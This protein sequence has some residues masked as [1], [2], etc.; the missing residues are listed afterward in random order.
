MP[1]TDKRTLKNK[2]LNLIL[3]GIDDKKGN[4][5]TVINLKKFDNT[6]ADYFVITDATTNVQVKAI[7]DNVRK[8]LS[9]DLKAKPLGVEGESL[10]EWILLDYGD[11]IVHVFQRPVREY[12]DIES[13]WEDAETIKPNN[14]E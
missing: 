12:Y 3:Q 7:A 1:K 4:D 5:T 8:M 10:A 9:K 2:K 14:D 13:L 6:I 11:V